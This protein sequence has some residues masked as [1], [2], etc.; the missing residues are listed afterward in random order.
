MSGTWALI[1]KRDV[2]VDVMLPIVPIVPIEVSD[3]LEPARDIRGLRANGDNDTFAK[4]TNIPWFDGQ[5][6]YLK[7]ENAW[8]NLYY[9]VCT[10]K[11][12]LFVKHTEHHRR[13]HHFCRSVHPIEH[14]TNFREQISFRQ[15]I[16]RFQHDFPFQMKQSHDRQHS[17]WFLYF[18]IKIQ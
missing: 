4:G 5:L 18:A 8:E 13:F 16:A 7:T 6:K 2:F 15:C 1:R 10:A 14:R 11:A 17:S 12:N 9:F 3:S